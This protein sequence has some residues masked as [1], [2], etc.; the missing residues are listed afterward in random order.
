MTTTNDDHRRL[1]AEALARA[2]ADIGELR[3]RVEQLEAV[4]GDLA[5]CRA[6]RAQLEID[7]AGVMD[8]VSWRATAP[9]RL[10]AARARALRE[11][12]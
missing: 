10:A 12:G 1:L 3:G 11:R 9:L 5:V 8:S 7:L 2:D 6:E 4:E